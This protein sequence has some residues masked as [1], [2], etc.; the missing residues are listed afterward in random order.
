MNFKVVNVFVFVQIKTDLD[1]FLIQQ[2]LNIT[3]MSMSYF[4][5]AY[6]CTHTHT[7]THI[8]TYIHT[9]VNTHPGFRSF[10]Q[11]LRKGENHLCFANYLFWY[12]LG[13]KATAQ[14]LNW[15]TKHR[16]DFL[17]ILGSYTKQILLFHSLL[18]SKISNNRQVY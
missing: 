15:L 5:H 14:I 3:I 13:R 16:W 18:S 4:R 1:I 8:H 12:F 10:G 2:F 6:T 11:Q 9:Y 7:H 17:R